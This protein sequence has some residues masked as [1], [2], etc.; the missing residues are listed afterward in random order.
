M[1][2]PF[3]YT[4]NNKRYHTLDY[5]YKNKFGKKVCKISLNAGFTCPN[6]DGTKG[7]GGCIYCSKLGSGDF[8][9][10]KEKDLITQFNEVKEIMKKKWPDALYI[11]YF[12]ANTNTY[13]KTEVLKQKYEPI[14]EQKNVIGLN[15]ATRPDAITEDCLDYLEE[16]STRT[17]LTVELG[18]QTIHEKTTKLINRG[19]DLECFTNMVKELRKRN[20]NVVVHIINGL[21]YETKEMMLETVEYLNKLD[22]QGI[23][24][25]MLHIIKDTRLA[26]LYNQEKF[27]ILTKEEYIDI[28]IEQ[29]ERL[30][31]EIIINRITGDPVKEDLIEPTWLLKKFCVLNDID[32]EMVKR[33]SYQGKL[34]S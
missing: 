12:Q 15:I 11:G 7:Y 9:G 14:L 29:L 13:A 18:L 24:I 32:K 16:L 30:R 4:D 2:N 3:Q 8:A 20:I 25:H 27:H 17:Y 33:N 22:I 34:I 28:V 1:Q 21:P 26:N 5:F 10:N 6:K 19:H 23:K 31:P